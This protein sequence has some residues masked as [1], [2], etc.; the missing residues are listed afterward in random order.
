MS[1]RLEELTEEVGHIEEA[2][3]IEMNKCPHDHELTDRLKRKLARA[4]DELETV[5]KAEHPDA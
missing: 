1:K 3:L 5:Y 4:K 2:L